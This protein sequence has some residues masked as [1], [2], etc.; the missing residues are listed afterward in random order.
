[1]LIKSDDA[2]LG[3][4]GAIIGCLASIVPRPAPTTGIVLIIPPF[5]PDL[6]YSGEERR[7]R[8]RSC[9]LIIAASPVIASDYTPLHLY[10]L[11]WDNVMIASSVS[12][13]SCVL[14]SSLQSDQVFQSCA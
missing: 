1:M 4:Y 13:Q 3:D 11:G 6:S 7:R 14:F 10:T 5:I 12:L 2:E 9:Q 8:R